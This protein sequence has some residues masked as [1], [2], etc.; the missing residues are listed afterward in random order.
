MVN[1]P[2]GA[3]AGSF[4]ELEG[5]ILGSPQLSVCG[6]VGSATV[7]GL[8][9]VEKCWP[10]EGGVVRRVSLVGSSALHVM[11]EAL[12]GLSG[13]ADPAERLAYAQ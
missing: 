1:A 11:P 6:K 4:S 9:T 12:N 7:S 3:E 13:T 10:E 8:L 2:A 5:M